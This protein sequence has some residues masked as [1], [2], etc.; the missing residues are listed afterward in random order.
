[1]YFTW[2]RAFTSAPTK[3]VLLH[4]HLQGAQAGAPDTSPTSSTRSPTRPASSCTP[5]RREAC[6]VRG[7]QGRHQALVVNVNNAHYVKFPPTFA[8]RTYE[9]GG[10]RK[11]C[12]CKVTEDK[13]ESKKFFTSFDTRRC[14]WFH[15][16][17][18]DTEDDTKQ[19]Q[20]YK[21]MRLSGPDVN[22]K[23]WKTVSDHFRTVCSGL[24]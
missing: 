7:P 21:C 19:I 3:R 15:N 12:V 2:S 17:H 18:L 4:L 14:S 5:T 6:R 24:A 13:L 22:L 10:K 11:T 8:I 20:A 9:D 23:D 16:V 1:V